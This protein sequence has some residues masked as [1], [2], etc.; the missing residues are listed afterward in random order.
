[1]IEKIVARNNPAQQLAGFR[2]GF[3]LHITK[4]TPVLA[5]AARKLG[6]EIAICSANP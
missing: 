4:E 6:A 1:M 2:L 5:I 3:C